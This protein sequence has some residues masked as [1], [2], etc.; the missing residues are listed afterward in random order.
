MVAL[1]LSP[2]LRSPGMAVK[3]TGR[4]ER[5]MGKWF[6]P[7]GSAAWQVKGSVTMLRIEGDNLRAVNNNDSTEFI[8]AIGLAFT[9]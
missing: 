5:A 8:G 7:P 6:I 9:Y 2:G 4:G 3:T 1:V